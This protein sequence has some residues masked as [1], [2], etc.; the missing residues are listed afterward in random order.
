MIAFHFPRPRPSRGRS[1]RPP[2]PKPPGPII[3]FGGLPF[4]ITA[5]PRKT[6]KRKKRKYGRRTIIH[7]AITAK[8][9]LG[10]ALMGK[11]KVKRAGVRLLRP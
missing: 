2:P 6:R 8:S 1:G 3:P 7:P 4:D 5:K 10:F 11:R 9:W